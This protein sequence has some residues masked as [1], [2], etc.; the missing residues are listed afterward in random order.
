MA[1]PTNRW[2]PALNVE[3]FIKAAD[4]PL[5]LDGADPRWPLVAKEWVLPILYA[6]FLDPIGFN[7]E[8]SVED[9]VD[10][11][12]GLRVAGYQ[13]MPDNL[14][15][16]VADPANGEPQ[17]EDAAD[18]WSGENY[19]YINLGYRM[20]MR[21]WIATALEN[22]NVDFEVRWGDSSQ[23]NLADTRGAWS[24]AAMSLFDGPTQVADHLLYS[25]HGKRLGDASWE[26]RGGHIDDPAGAF[27]PTSAVVSPWDGV[28]A[29]RV[30]LL[31]TGGPPNWTVKT[32]YWDPGIPDWVD[33]TSAVV[34]LH[35][36]AVPGY[37][38]LLAM[39]GYVFHGATKVF[40]GA[41]PPTSPEQE[42][43][44]RHLSVSQFEPFVL[45][46]GDWNAREFVARFER[47]MGPVLPPG[48]FELFS[49][50]TK[51]PAVDIIHYPEGTAFS[52]EKIRDYDDDGGWGVLFKEDTVLAMFGV[53][54]RKGITTTPTMG[55]Y[56]PLCLCDQDFIGS[57]LPFAY[58]GRY[59]LKDLAT[60][61]TERCLVSFGRAGFR[62]APTSPLNGLGMTWRD[63]NG[64]ELV[65][66]YWDGGAP[67]WLELTAP[68]RIDEYEDR[69]V[70]IG[71]A[72][73]G[74]FGDYLPGQEGYQLR[75]LVDGVTVSS[76]IETN[77]IVESTWNAFIGTGNPAQRLSFLGHWFGG[78]TFYEP[79]FDEDIAHAFDEV[80][81]GGFENPSFEI[82]AA[83]GRPGEAE[84]WE[85]QSLQLNG[86]WADFCAYRADLA[87]YR[88]G[89]EGFEGGWLWPATWIYPDATARLAAVGFTADDVG[90]AAWQL[91]VNRN[92]VLTDFAPITWEEAI[93]GEN[94]D[95]ISELSDATIAAAVFNG[96]IPNFETTMEIFE[97]WGFPP[98][99]SP[100]YTGPPWMDAY[101]LIPPC[102]DTL[103]P[104]GGPT[105]FDGWY[106]H[107]YGTN[108]D[109]ICSESFEEAWGNDPLSTAGGQ[110]WMADSAPSGE[111]RGEALT[112]P[113]FIPPNENQLVILTDAITPAMF[114]LPTSSYADLT[115][116]VTDLNLA[117]LAHGITAL[118]LRFGQ[119][120]EGTEE[121]LTF[122]WD[123]ATYSAVWWGFAALESEM[124]KDARE[125]LGLRS[126]SPGGNYTG[127][128]IPAWLYLTLPAGVATT[129]R[130]LLDTWSA[131]SILIVTDPV[132]G[133]VILEND[134]AGAIFDSAVPDPTL[135]ERFTLQGWIDP[136]AVWIPDLS[137]VSLTQALFDS[138]TATEEMFLDTEWPDEMFPT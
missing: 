60:W 134:M 4:G 63:T 68:L 35:S 110:R 5:I 131:N 96:G 81:E 40:P 66:K 9:G 77:L 13:Y 55:K 33:I 73:S 118:G 129:D 1:R 67:A 114:S 84:D 58:V 83:D 59:R 116:L 138:G 125:K 113:L 90:K 89:R 69:V 50:L 122:G 128:G 111:M 62:A 78:A 92:Y 54:D 120:S 57:F 91:D 3:L 34:D 130:F 23:R 42:T 94:Q 121:G 123:G 108:L 32:Q 16:T 43:F 101:N 61:G 29:G 20:A 119:W 64:G 19:R 95:W 105:G 22:L 25:L 46:R 12:R 98:G 117:L 39:N 72:W 76:V 80:G 24:G 47:I 27:I 109:P 85:W 107:L 15:Y 71:F 17:P 74:I 70:D 48:I 18:A 30:R 31:I 79:C 11:Q 135:M 127:V 103:G 136:A 75:I 45:D 106:D 14:A 133:V 49:T 86:A 126:F 51:A 87:P 104:F 102:E 37:E 52:P 36:H 112:F 26:Y 21:G 115:T 100:T 132:L 44:F 2:D 10:P 65:L 97:L 53:E 41:F 8:V 88:Y 137:A 38:D 93:V 56:L 82:P 99:D 28:D 7:Q 124:F 6:S